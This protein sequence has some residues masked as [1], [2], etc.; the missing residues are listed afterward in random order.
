M[1][2][3]DSFSQTQHW[4]R[5]PAARCKRQLGT[6]T[7]RRL[8]PK[9][10]KRRA[11]EKETS[12]AVSSDHPPASMRSLKHQGSLQLSATGQRTMSVD[13]HVYGTLIQPQSTVW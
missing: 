9:R 12:N 4:R 6:A 10:R 3:I 1:A 8:M 11:E 5:S 7:S 2:A 13:R